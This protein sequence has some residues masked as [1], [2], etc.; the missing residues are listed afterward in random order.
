MDPTNSLNGIPITVF[1]GRCNRKLVLDEPHIGS[2]NGYTGG[3]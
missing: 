1:H 2:I 3:S